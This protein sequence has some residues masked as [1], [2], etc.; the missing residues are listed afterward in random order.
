MTFA[1]ADTAPAA[2]LRHGGRALA[3]TV[4]HPLS[5]LSAEELQLAAEILRENG[6]LGESGRISYLGLHEPEKS[7]VLAH[8]DGDAVDRAAHALVIDLDTGESHSA[9]VSIS[10]RA[11]VSAIPVDPVGDGQVPLLWEEHLMVRKLLPT[12]ERWVAALAARGIVDPSTVVIG[13]LSAGSYEAGGERGARLARILGFLRPH[14]GA[15]PWAHP[16]DGLVALVDMIEQRVVEV[17]DTGVLPVPSES[18]DYHIPGTFGPERTTLKPIVTTQ[19]EGPSFTIEGSVVTWENWSFRVGYD[20][21]EGLVLHQ[22]GFEDA[23]R[24]RPILYRASVAE[25]VVPYGDPS[26][27]RFWHNYFD[28]G[29]YQLGSLANSL[30]LGCD[31]VGEIAYFDV[32]IPAADG[33]PRNLPNAVCM[34]EEDA[35]ILWKHFEESN[36]TSETRRQRRLVISFF[37][38]VGNYDY[39]FYWYLYLDGTI[40]LEAKATGIV[41]TSAYDARSAAYASELAPGLAAP[42]HQHL[43]NVRLDMTVDGTRNAVDEIDVAPVETSPDNPWGNAIGRSVRRLAT[44]SEGARVANNNVDRVWRVSNP[45]VTNRLGQP[46][47]YVLIPEGKQLLAAQEGSVI[48]E[49]AAFATRHLWVTRYEPSERFP[50]GDIVNQG[51][52][53]QGL[54]KYA[55]QNRAIDGEDIVLWHTFGLTHF[56]RTEDWPIMPVDSC[57]FVMKPLNFFD[58]NPTLDVPRPRENSDHCAA[59]QSSGHDHHH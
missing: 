50:S 47:A 57:R 10:D 28:T 41:F 33:T 32:T 49:R 6:L 51:A 26:P 40:E 13:A 17:L 5:P 39:G 15:L 19:P 2:G 14:P 23:G 56:P 20:M 4:I 59:P 54:P 16:I 58:R 27:V 30:E 55:A 24:V 45:D 35:G 48:A 43:F 21:R 31:C 8:G 3:D 44:E 42:Y 22:L 29:E 34:H 12:D 11:L 37:V 46:V 9:V 53:G 7:V 25:M 1:S 38:T 36:G 52:L 18:G